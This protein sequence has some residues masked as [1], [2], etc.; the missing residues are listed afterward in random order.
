MT[1]IAIIHY[2]D[3]ISAH[4]GYSDYFKK[5]GFFCCW[6][7]GFVFVRLLGLFLFGFF[8]G[9]GSFGAFYSSRFGNTLR[10]KVLWMRT[11]GGK[12]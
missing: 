9:G 12:N 10:V 6:F 8:F 1:P 11:A 5:Q 7:F 3:L 2:T 4:F